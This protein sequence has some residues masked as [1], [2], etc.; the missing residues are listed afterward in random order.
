M[1][2][3]EAELNR[4][5]SAT[6]APAVVWARADG[7]AAAMPKDRAVL[8]V[9]PHGHGIKL[10]ANAT[11]VELPIKCFRVLHPDRKARYRVLR[12]GRGSAKSWSIARVLI[13]AAL[14]SRI[15]VLCAREFQKSIAESA[16]RLLA[17]QIESLGLGRWFDVKAQSI[18]SHTGSEFLFEGVFANANKLKSLEGIN[19]CWIEE[20]ATISNSSLEILIPTIRAAGS[21]FIINFNPEGIDDPVYKR[22]VISP[23]PD[24]LVDHLT[25]RDNPWFPDELRKEMEYLR[26]VDMDAFQ[27][28]WEGECRR[29]SDAQVFKGKYVVQEFQPAEGWD[30]PYLGVDFGFSQDPT[31]LVK[32]WVEN[33]RR[34][35][36]EYEAYGI[37]VDIDKTPE[38]FAPVPGATE[39]VIRADSARPETIS[40]LRQHGFPQMAGVDKGPNSVEEGIRFLRQFEQ[41]VIHPRCTH[42]QEEARLYSFKVDRLTGDVLPDLVDRHNHIWDAVRYA[43]APLIKAG[44]A[45]NALFL[46]LKGALAQRQQAEATAAKPPREQLPGARVTSLTTTETGWDKPWR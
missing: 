44:G 18:T 26:G 2:Q 41:I 27:H 33:Y 20:A 38:L 14:S 19:I 42:A 25:F 39:H 24:S 9:V 31:T 35:Y 3:A 40:Y 22:F 36:I 46:Y 10:P 37:G 17:D 45:G 29:Q 30:G 7:S 21:F 34:L 32:C 1:R 4:R 11:A 8:A 6:T 13:L 43:L 5:M 12:G 15:R 23:P 16:H 28:V